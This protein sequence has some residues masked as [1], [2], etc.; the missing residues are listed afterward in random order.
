ML[1][2]QA[3]VF[4]LPIYLF[5]Y[6]YLFILI[7]SHYLKLV[8]FNTTYKTNFFLQNLFQRQLT[9]SILYTLIVD[10]MNVKWQSI[11]KALVISKLLLYIP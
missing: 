2:R 3:V 4:R 11:C 8:T 9:I 1:C 10:I 7:V 6:L 5:I